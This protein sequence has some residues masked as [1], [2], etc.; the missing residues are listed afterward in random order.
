[1][2]KRPDVVVVGGGH[3]G[4]VAAALLARAGRSVTLLE[5]S[6]ELGGAAVSQAP[7]RGVDVRL[8]RY[9]YL[10]SLFPR[11]L[12]AGL[13]IELELARRAIG[14]C[15]PDGERSLLIRTGESNNEELVRFTGDIRAG[16]AWLRFYEGVARLAA[17]VFPT[18]TEPLITRAQMRAR[19][20]D[21]ELWEA[22][23]ERPLG[24]VLERTFAD[25]T[26]RGLVAT[27]ALIG[28]F[29]S[30]TDPG[31]AQNRCF[32]YHVIGNGEGT[33]D[34]PV[35]G[36][37][38]VSEA[39]AQ[40]AL[41]AGVEIVCDREVTGVDADQRGAVVR[42]TGGGTLDAGGV[43]WAAGPR[44]LFGRPA[45]NAATGCQTKINMV[46]K[47]LPR[48]RDRSCDPR[49]AFA[50]TLHVHESASQLE[51][52]F[53][54]AAAGRMPSPLPC[55]IYCH[56]LADRSILGPELAATGAQTLTLFGLHTPYALFTDNPDRAREQ[57]L[58]AALTALDAEFL[59]PIESCLMKDSG[60]RPCIEVRTP[61]DLERELGMDEGNI[62][63]G[64]LQWPW[65]EDEADAGSWGV[66][67]ELPGVVLGSAAARRGGG[68]SGIPGH[69]AARA[70]LERTVSR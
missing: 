20:G 63:H 12:A 18:L 59:D 32:L 68:V 4:L 3:N 28:T 51:R 9:A 26:V 13:G 25:D 61:F 62:F 55:E 70:L 41:M 34:V 43:V 53:R 36:M 37:G 44:E 24:E 47:R 11:S 45:P 27:D 64:E 66:E 67:T 39:L 57:V 38:A 7:F 69:N 33:W 46:L 42:T 40:A 21:D 22:L 5:R 19:V 31:L 1:M 17:V 6:Q 35:G 54:T 29:A 15:T 60:G 50:G 52:A 65:A 2:A 56:T 49:E 8:S 48:L 14:S 23:I 58:R 30:L 16:R 10:V